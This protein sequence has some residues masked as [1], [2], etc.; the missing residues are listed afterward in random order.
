MNVTACIIGGIAL[1]LVSVGVT[2]TILTGIERKRHEREKEKIRQE[3]AENARH[4]AEAIEKA[5]RDKSEVRTGNHA[6]D[7]HTMADKLH[8]Y[9]HPDK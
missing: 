5:D 2:A 4:T 8:G 9:A 6:N 7:L 1:V 3:G